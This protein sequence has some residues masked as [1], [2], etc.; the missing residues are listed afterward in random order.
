MRNKINKLIKLFH[1]GYYITSQIYINDLFFI[2]AI[3]IKLKN[4]INFQTRK[5]QY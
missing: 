4:D 5:V 3:L 1:F 2:T